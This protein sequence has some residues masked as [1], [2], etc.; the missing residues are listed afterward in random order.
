MRNLRRKLYY[1]EVIGV[2]MGKN[3][4]G[5]AMYDY[6]MGVKVFSPTVN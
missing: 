6:P 1:D 5:D 3:K 4:T 2:N